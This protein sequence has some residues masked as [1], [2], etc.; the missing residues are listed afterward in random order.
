MHMIRRYQDIRPQDVSDHD[1]LPRMG[2]AVTIQSS[3]GI[4]GIVE[5]DDPSFT[6]F[7]VSRPTAFDLAWSEEID[8]LARKLGLHLVPIRQSRTL[9]SPMK[10]FEDF[11]AFAQHPFPTPPERLPDCTCRTVPGAIW[12]DENGTP[13][14]VLDGRP[15]ADLDGD[16]VPTDLAYEDMLTMNLT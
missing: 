6:I 8:P 2:I 13:W 5:D 1:G 9:C 12:L 14:P 15:L 16:P 11:M 10:T 4:H 7:Q 3:S